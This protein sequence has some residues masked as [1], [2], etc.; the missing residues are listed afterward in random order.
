MSEGPLPDATARPEG[1]TFPS[2]PDAGVPGFPEPGTPN[3]QERSKP[4]ISGLL[5]MQHM[6]E[7]MGCG[8]EGNAPGVHGERST[9]GQFNPFKVVLCLTPQRSS[10]NPRPMRCSGW[11]LAVLPQSR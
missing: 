1:Q 2:L 7:I 10:Q 4:P 5:P 11:G 3:A 6:A 9:H 8:V